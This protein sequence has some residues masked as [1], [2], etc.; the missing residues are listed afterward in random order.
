M[1]IACFLEK[2]GPDLDKLTTNAELSP[3]IWDDN[4]N[5]IVLFKEIH[6]EERTALVIQRD[7]FGAN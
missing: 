5:T 2:L 1:R 6:Q 3:I 7:S 4:F